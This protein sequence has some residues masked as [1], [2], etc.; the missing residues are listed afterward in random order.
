MLQ[1]TKWQKKSSI[2]SWKY[3]IIHLT[4]WYMLCLGT[5]WTQQIEQWQRRSLIYL[6]LPGFTEQWAKSTMLPPKLESSD[7]RRLWQQSGD[8]K[9]HDFERRCSTNSRETLDMVF[10]A[11][12][13]HMDGL[14]LGWPSLQ[15]QTRKWWLGVS[16]SCREYLWMQRSGGIRVTLLW[17]D[18]ER[19]RMLLGL[20]FFCQVPFQRM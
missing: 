7:S 14:I 12:L 16:R 5:G 18:L 6:R 8:G 19:W 15:I 9:W 10:V 3:I 17:A 11:M 13:W 1:S 2:P 4:A 20:C